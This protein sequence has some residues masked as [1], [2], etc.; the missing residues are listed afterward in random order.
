MHFTLYVFS[1]LHCTSRSQKVPCRDRPWLLYSGQPGSRFSQGRTSPSSQAG[2]RRHGIS[3]S[4]RGSNSS[5]VVSGWIESGGAGRR[6]CQVC[7]LLGAGRW[8][9]RSAPLS[10]IWNL[11]ICALQSAHVKFKI[12]QPGSFYDVN[13]SDFLRYSKRPCIARCQ[14]SIKAFCGIGEGEIPRKNEVSRFQCFSFFTIIG[15]VR[16]CLTM[17]RL[18]YAC[19]RFWTIIK[20]PL[21]WSRE[22]TAQKHIARGLSGTSVLTAPKAKQNRG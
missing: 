5:G 21:P 1:T 8:L 13:V 4:L 11:G 3:F 19:L 16:C 22:S 7:R 15:T 14:T 9:E 10:R 12:F 18:I 17:S 20:R 2:S 6:E